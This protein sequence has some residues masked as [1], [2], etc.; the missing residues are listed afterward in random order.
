MELGLQAPNVEF[1]QSKKK[2][3]GS[4]IRLSK[5]ND[6][7][8]KDDDDWNYKM[9]DD[10][11]ITRIELKNQAKDPFRWRGKVLNE[12]ALNDISVWVIGDSFTTSI[13]PFIEA[14]F[15]E[16][17]YIGHWNKKLKSLPSELAD[18][19]EKPDLIIVVRAERSF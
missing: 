18:S 16:V 9:L 6:F 8:L 10:S 15:K 3:S 17:S 13:R 12:K 7:P 11:Q 2:I 4:L 14:L 5:L 19:A 1:K